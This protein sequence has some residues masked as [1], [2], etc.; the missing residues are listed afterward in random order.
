MHITSAFEKNIVGCDILQMSQVKLVD[1]NDQDSSL[2][3]LLDTER[4]MYNCGFSCFSFEVY[5]FFL[6]EF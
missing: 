6:Q 1:S 3:V 5:Q 2:L 4:G